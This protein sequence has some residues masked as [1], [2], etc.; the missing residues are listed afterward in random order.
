MDTVYIL[1]AFISILIFLLYISDKKLIILNL[2]NLFGNPLLIIIL[3]GLLS[4]FF[5]AS[6]GYTF[7]SDIACFKGW[8]EYIYTYGLK[9]FYSS[10]LLSFKDYPPG[11]MYILWLLGFL[12]NI[13]KLDENSFTTLIL[14]PANIFDIITACFIYKAAVKKANASS[15]FILAFIYI[16]NPAIIINSAVWGQV[17][18]VHTFFIMLSLFY[19]IDKKYIKSFPV[20]ALAVLIKPQ[21]FTFSPIYLY[22]LY[23]GVKNNKNEILNIL[24]GVLTAAALFILLI[25]PFTSNLNFM[26]I[27]NLYKETLAS[28]PY[29]TVNAY[30]L[31]ALLGK[32][33]ADLNTTLLGIPFT[34]WGLF[35]LCAITTA[36]FFLLH[37]NHKGQGVF[38]TAAFLCVSSF[39]LSVKMHER[40]IYPSLLFLILSYIYQAGEKEQKDILFLYAGFSVTLFI[41]CADILNIS[42]N[43]W[44]YTLIEGSLFI[45]SLFNL[46]LF[47]FMLLVTF[48]EKREKKRFTYKTD[49]IPF[50]K[51]DVA[52]ESKFTKYDRIFLF[53]LIAVYSVIA[54]WR[55]GDTRAPQTLCEF[56]NNEPAVAEVLEN[57]QFNKIMYYPGPVESGNVDVYYS[58]DG[59][60]WNPVCRLTQSHVL[61]WSEA[62]FIITGS[63]NAK[64]LKFNP[65]ENAAMME[66]AVI[67]TDNSVIPVKL[68]SR[69][70]SELF[71]EQH[72]VPDKPT[73]MNGTYFD[74]I[75]YARTAY[76]FLNKIWPYEQTHPPLGKLFI[77]L[78]V[79]AFGLT[80]FGWRFSGTLFGILMLP[81]LYLF[82]RFIFKNSFWSFF[83]CF[84]FS[85]DF[86]HFVQT[87]LTTIDTYVVFFIILMYYFMYKYM[88]LTLEGKPF[89]KTFIPLALSG[90]STGFAIASK[91]QGVYAIT[92]IAFIFF[93]TLIKRYFNI[94][95]TDKKLF[96]KNTLITILS[97]F[98]FFIILPLAV[99]ILSYIPF[100]N[101]NGANGFKTIINN[102]IYMFN[103]HTTLE[104]RH[105]YSS[106]WWQWPLMLRPIFLYSAEFGSR[107]VAGISSFGNPAVWWAGI[108]ALIYSAVSV[109][110]P[111]FRDTALFIIIGYAS[112]FLPWV[113][114]SR[115]TFIYHYFPCVP[116]LT[117]AITFFFKNYVVIKKPRLTFTYL[118]V[119]ILLFILFYPVLSG[120]P[121]PYPFIAFLRWLPKWQFVI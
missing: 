115:T 23:M 86:M 77:A 80:P 4:R 5:A 101:V 17:D 27:I 109:K 18:S 19:L 121:F 105:P 41:N 88:A 47:L 55:L 71:D 45:V 68:I 34:A 62:D 50:T 58:N 24:K 2:S 112:Q 22:F 3:L 107:N 113:G 118:A 78:C 13:L 64:Y 92:G 57:N 75:Y 28:Y 66:I 31:Y 32:N 6:L 67:G 74:E 29:A 70:G 63:I 84:I 25:L 111:E 1:T 110:K 7:K 89:I 36:S 102:Q 14:V 100:L 73:Y 120:L 11:Y 79:K 60:E 90:L 69:T 119:V 20:F 21:A 116:F 30:N 87:R 99:Y 93:Y 96:I 56:V 10:E 42:L 106:Q 44:D 97:C 51:F 82:A 83:A 9:N 35:F 117:L 61:A 8:A 38:L 103:Y 59:V 72:L 54:F 37:K 40:Y 65:D 52:K 48:N 43:S 81:F 108:P 53:T 91:W 12:Q 39:M 104:Q 76:E 114:V 26:P 85:F 15:A 49:T 16:L 95:K 94:K 98:L 46:L 33:W